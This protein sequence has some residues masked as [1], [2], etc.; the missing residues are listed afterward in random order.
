MAL[1]VVG[2][3]Q[4]TPFCSGQGGANFTHYIK[5]WESN[6]PH[7]GA[8]EITSTGCLYP[9]VILKEYIVFGCQCSKAPRQKIPFQK[10]VWL[11]KPHKSCRAGAMAGITPHKSDSWEPLSHF[12]LFPFLRRHCIPCFL[13]S[14]LS[15]CEHTD[16]QIQNRRDFDRNSWLQLPSSWGLVICAFCF[17]QEFQRPTEAVTTTASLTACQTWGKSGSLHSP[18]LHR[19]KTELKDTV[20]LY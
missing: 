19:D 11:M 9:E 4:G 10:K 2:Q 14:S 16:H 7:L 20:A 12:L 8:G 1:L 6:R 5:I 15:F 18:L 13:F 17:S 3:R